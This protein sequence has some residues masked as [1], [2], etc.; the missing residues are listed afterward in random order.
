[1]P[2]AMIIASQTCCAGCPTGPCRLA[3]CSA[4]PATPGLSRPDWLYAPSALARQNTRRMYRGVAPYHPQ[5]SRCGFAECCAFVPAA[6]H[7]PFLSKRSGF[8]CLPCR[9]SPKFCAW[10]Q[11]DFGGGTG[12]PY[13]RLLHR[14]TAFAALLFRILLVYCINVLLPFLLEKVTYTLR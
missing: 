5:N 12:Q 13:M 11:N 7:Q 4:V 1:M 10:A 8:R 9:V 14:K 2:L 3:M 6:P